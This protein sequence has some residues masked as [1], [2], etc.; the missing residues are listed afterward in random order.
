MI[1]FFIFLATACWQIDKP[2]WNY[3]SQ[4]VIPTKCVETIR[5]SSSPI[6]LP[7][8]SYLCAKIGCDWI[9]K[10]PPFYGCLVNHFDGHCDMNDPY[11]Q[12]RWCLKRRRN[13]TKESWEEIK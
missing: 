11:E 1:P 9:E 10:R 8:E 7:G 2:V 6:L 3:K 12:C 5:V 4:M 13:V